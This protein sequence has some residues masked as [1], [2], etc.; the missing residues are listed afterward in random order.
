VVHA[1]KDT[2]KG[3]AGAPVACGVVMLDG[4]PAETTTTRTN[5]SEATPSPASAK[6]K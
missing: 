4:T 1:R 6:S 5:Y 3:S 2:A